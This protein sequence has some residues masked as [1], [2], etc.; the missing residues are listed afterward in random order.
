MQ[1]PPATKTTNKITEKVIEVEEEE[2]EEEEVIILKNNPRKLSKILIHK[3]KMF[4][5][6]QSNKNQNQI[7]L[8]SFKN[9]LSHS[10]LG[11]DTHLGRAFVKSYEVLTSGVL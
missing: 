6:Y 7:T 11:C 5:C 3:I 10:V 8:K 1:P 2:E 4:Q 9:R